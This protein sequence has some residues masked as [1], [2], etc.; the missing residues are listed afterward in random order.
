M[1]EQNSWTGLVPANKEHGLKTGFQLRKGDF[2]S[3]VATGYIRF[4]K[5]SR[6]FSDPLGTIPSSDPIDP[7][8]PFESAR[9]RALIGNDGISYPIGTGVL[10]WSVPYDGELTF[11]VRDNPGDYADNSG[12]FTV[13][14]QKQKRAI[15]VLV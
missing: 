12:S 15:V 11:L 8:Y 1:D 10:N 3:V 2:I 7:Y 6:Q 5:G 4:G 9:L 13:T 14:V